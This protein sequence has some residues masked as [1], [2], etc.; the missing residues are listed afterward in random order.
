MIGLLDRLRS[1]GLTVEAID[2]SLSVGPRHLLTDLDRV[3]IRE[4]KAEL[5]TALASPETPRYWPIDWRE[6]HRLEVA[7]LRRR[8]AECRDGP[9]R[10]R[11]LA[12]ADE[13]VNDLQ[14]H[15]AWGD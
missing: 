11:L 2:G 6:E 5:L 4:H 8:A 12:L 1:R 3:L 14:Q 15:L 7:A 9:K 10:Q 13:P